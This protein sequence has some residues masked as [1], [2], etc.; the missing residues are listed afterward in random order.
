MLRNGFTLGVGMA[1]DETT[2]GVPIF[3]LY[4]LYNPPAEDHFYTTDPMERQ[5]FLAQGNY[6]SEGTTAWICS[7]M[8]SGTKPLYRLYD[9]TDHFYTTSI[10]EMERALALGYRREGQVGFVFSSQESNTVP[11]YR[12]RHP[13]TG[14]HFYTISTVE[15]AASTKVGFVKEG[16][17]GYV[18]A[19]APVQPAIAT[20]GSKGH[21][22]GQ[23]W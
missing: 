4:R 7:E 23:T 6:H 17:V 18:Y 16:I 13:Q 9:G 22:E 19:A 11:L 20:V 14:D 5:R 3:P 15:V 1:S 21:R 8:R 10:E 2:S 12:L